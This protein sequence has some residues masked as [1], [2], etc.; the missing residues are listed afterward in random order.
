VTQPDSRSPHNPLQP[1]RGEQQ[2][3]VPVPHAVRRRG[4]R[5]RRN[6]H[7][8][9]GSAAVL[10]A[11]AVVLGAAQLG[12]PGGGKDVGVADPAP[13][14]TTS[15][16]STRA[17]LPP[18]PLTEALPRA[19][20]LPDPQLHGWVQTAVEPGVSCY[21]TVLPRGGSYA[22]RTFSSELSGT[23][24]VLAR[25]EADE[26]SASATVATAEAAFD[27]CVAADRA[28][29]AVTAGPD[30]TPVRG[31]DQGSLHAVSVTCPHP[32]DVGGCDIAEIHVGVVRIQ[33]SV[34][35]VEFASQGAVTAEQAAEV[36]ASA[37]NRVTPVAG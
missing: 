8:A 5:R 14:P 21:D 12:L 22:R 34:V 11:A 16:T 35:F 3:G 4:E 33:R 15:S 17:A 30:T 29:D 7:L 27:A 10:A 23:A 2:D 1:L 37:V 36:L 32:E 26:P 25:R 31:A 20:E 24:V 13:A 28:V 18:G 19:A 9:Q 6:R